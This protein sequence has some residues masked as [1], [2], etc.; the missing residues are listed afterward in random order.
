MIDTGTPHACTRGSDFEGNG[1]EPTQLCQR[2]VRIE[3]EAN[4]PGEVSGRGY[5]LADEALEG[6]LYDSQALRDFVG[7]DLSRESVPDATTMLKFTRLLLDN[8]L[9]KAL[10]EEINAHL[11]E[12]GLPM[13]AGTIVGATSIAAHSLT[14]NADNTRDPEMQQTKKGKNTAQLLSLF[15]LANL[16]IARKSLLDCYARGAS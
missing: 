1:H 11:A 13:R 7:I 4:A 15:G 6:A 14:K 12:Q 3:E 5:G 16:V 10:F 8:D 2:R 9:T